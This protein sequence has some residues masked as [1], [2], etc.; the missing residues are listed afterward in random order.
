MTSMV[1]RGRPEP[2]A[3]IALGESTGVV[4]NWGTADLT[5]RCVRAIIE[6]GF[7]AGR[8]VVVDNGSEDDS[9]PRLQRALP[10]CLVHRIEKNIGY[11]RAA[12]AGARL[13]AGT[14]YLFVN[15]DAFVHRPG[16]IQALA[17][18]LEDDSVGIVIAKV[19]NEDL[20][21]QRQTVPIRT[22]A[23][24]LALATGLS[25][26]VPNRWQPRWGW[27]W[28]HSESRE[29]AAA[30]MVGMLVRGETWERLGGFA[31]LAWMYGEDLDLC[32]RARN[33]GKRVWFTTEAEFVHLEA[34]STSL[35]YD[36]V[37][38]AELTA[39]A[40]VEIVRRNL[41]PFSARVSLA[42]IGLGMIWPAVYHGIAGHRDA[43]ARSLGY[44][45]GHLAAIRETRPA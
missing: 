15:N 2:T 14:S 8:I 45:R 7:P 17:R 31:E 27:H 10:D 35:R 20:S 38:R 39:R 40:E 30:G 18:C 23:V 32:W 36:H 11:A 6:D 41:S 37:K 9:Y 1:E 4:V 19:L 26:F 25:W 33:M 44:L 24:A 3:P 13:L 5:I 29:I 42:L 28:D 34:A 43:A 16:S 22:P 21:L 12:N